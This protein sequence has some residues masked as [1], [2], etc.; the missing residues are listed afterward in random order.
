MPPR[1]FHRTS[2]SDL[3]TPPGTYIYTLAP[4]SATHLA[5]ST[6]SSSSLVTFSKSTLTPVATIPHAHTNITSLSAYPAS[7]QTLLTSG[8]DGLIKLWDL[9][10]SPPAAQA[11]KINVGAPALC[12]SANAQGGIIAGTEMQ[13]RVSRVCVWDGRMVGEKPTWVFAESHGDDVSFVG[14]A[15]G[16]EGERWGVSGGMDGLVSV[17]DLLAEKEARGK[18]DDDERALWQVVNVGASVHRA[19]FLN[20][21]GGGGGAA[22]KGEWVFGVST[23]ESLVLRSFNHAPGRE[24]EEDAAGEVAGDV[25]DVRKRLDCEYV[26]DVLRVGGTGT[27]G[28]VVAGNKEF[29]KQRVD[30][31]PLGWAGGRWGFTSEDKVRLQGGHGEEVCRGVWVD[32]DV[33]LLSS[34]LSSPGLRRRRRGKGTDG[35]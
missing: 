11:S 8:T 34:P 15:G 17:F 35:W 30:L 23:D 27:G 3:S 33:G 9:R 21:G 25:G 1:T 6:S 14:F 16:E 32:D 13:D 10:C 29:G 7:P 26:V 4:L 2:A 24:E 31:I 12:A 20:A 18:G 22:G 28:I 19:G 5:A